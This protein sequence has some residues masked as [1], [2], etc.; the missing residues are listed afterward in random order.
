MRFLLC[1]LFFTLQFRPFFHACAKRRVKRKR[2]NEKRGGR[3]FGR[4][5]LSFS[6]PRPCPPQSTPTNEQGALAKADSEAERVCQQPVSPSRL[7]TFDRR[8][9]FHPPSPHHRLPPASPPA[10]VLQKMWRHAVSNRGPSVNEQAESTQIVWKR[11][12][13]STGC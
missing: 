11:F 10:S 12:D 6:N 5:H 7:A 13:H 1:L 8:P 2:Q 9:P 3:F 4:R